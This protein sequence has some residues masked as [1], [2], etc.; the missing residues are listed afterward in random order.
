[1]AQTEGA[2]Q[3]GIV[4]FKV[5]IGNHNHGSIATPLGPTDSSGVRRADAT[6]AA[7]TRPGEY[8]V[9]AIFQGPLPEQ[10][11]EADSVTIRVVP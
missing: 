8:E 9:V 6:L 4:T 1:M 10:R 2:W 3:P 5:A 11:L 7:P